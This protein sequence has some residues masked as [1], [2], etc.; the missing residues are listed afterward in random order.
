[1]EDSF[2]CLVVGT[3]VDTIP[4]L[5]CLTCFNMYPIFNTWFKYC[6]SDY[7]LEQLDLRNPFS[8]HVAEW[9]SL[10]NSG[11]RWNIYSLDMVIQK[12]F[13]LGNQSLIGSKAS[14][15]KA[16]GLHKNLWI[17]YYKLP[18][19]SSLPRCGSRTLGFV[20]LFSG[21]RASLRDLTRPGEKTYQY[22]HL[23]LLSEAI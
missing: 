23:S 14:I 15:M 18:L 10:L 22:C 12:E 8:L 13:R 16:R 20:F 1:M 21:E 5:T 9:L 2:L 6:M 4:F 7:K 11:R 19:L 3:W 17:L